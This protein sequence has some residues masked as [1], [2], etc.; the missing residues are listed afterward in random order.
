MSSA[1]LK[2]HNAIATAE[3]MHA[4]GMQF[5]KTLHTNAVV[6][7]FGELGAGKTTFI[8][9]MAEGLAINSQAVNS[10]TFQYLNIYTGT[11]NL[12]HFDLYRL[13]TSDD[14][15]NMG[16]DDVFCQGGITCIEWAERISTILPK[17]S[18]RVAIYHA[19]NGAR[20]VEITDE[21]K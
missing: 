21:P 6:S 18:I 16:F 19:E 15:L 5:A 3:M 11:R 20:T 13:K 9:G 10:P 7:F 17:N 14:F 12:F 4:L 1:G 8:K 2:K